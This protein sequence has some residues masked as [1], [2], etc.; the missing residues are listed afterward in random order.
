MAGISKQGVVVGAWIRENTR[1][2]STVV[3]LGAGLFD[4]LSFVPP[5]C[6]RIGIDIF[7]AYLGYAPIGVTAMLGD[8]RDWERLIEPKRRDTAMLIDVIEHLPKP[9]GE[10]LLYGLV[11]SFRKVLVMT[12]DGYVRQDDD[13]TGFGNE[14]QNHECGWSKEELEDLGF[15][16]ELKPDFHPPPIGRGALFGVF[17]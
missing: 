11:R 4:K 17:E 1:G 8:I 6:H 5:T 14:F 7:P 2:S 12:P 15:V 9:D 10:A 16:V 3:D 13:A